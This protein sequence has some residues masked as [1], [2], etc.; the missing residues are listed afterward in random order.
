TTGTTGLDSLAHRVNELTQALDT[1]VTE[2]G[3]LPNNLEA[4]VKT[5]TD[6][7]DH[8]DSGSRDQAAFDQLER[9]IVGLAEKVEAADQ[10]FGNLGT[11]ERGIQQLTMQVRAAREDAAA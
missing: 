11:I 3:P 6:K 1:R 5:L 8:A 4:L 9:Q 10:K 7:L 2:M